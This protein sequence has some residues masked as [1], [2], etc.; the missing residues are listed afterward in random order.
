[1]RNPGPG[2]TRLDEKTIP[3]KDAMEIARYILEAFK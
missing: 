2:M 1:M 3:D